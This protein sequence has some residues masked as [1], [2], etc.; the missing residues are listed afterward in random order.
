[1]KSYSPRYSLRKSAICRWHRWNHFPVVSLTPLKLS[2][3]LSETNFPGVTDTTKHFPRCHWHRGDF[4]V[5]CY[6]SWHSCFSL[7]FRH[8][9]SGVIW[10][11]GTFSPLIVIAVSAVSV[12]RRNRFGDDVITIEFRCFFISWRMWN[13]VRNVYSPS[14]SGLL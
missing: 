10:L 6:S 8:D 7:P 13:H 2:T 4:D 11:H 9:F 14:V 5:I 1:M 12:H 3:W